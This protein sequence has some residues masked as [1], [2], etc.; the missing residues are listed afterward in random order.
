MFA[1]ITRG[2]SIADGCL[3]TPDCRCA[4][5]RAS[6]SPVRTSNSSSV[7]SCRLREHRCMHTCLSMETSPARAA[8]TSAVSCA[9]QRGVATSRSCGWCAATCP[10]TAGH[11]S[12][13]GACVSGGD[14]CRPR[15]PPR[16]T[17]VVEAVA[18]CDAVGVR[19]WKQ[20]T[21]VASMSACSVSASMEAHPAVSDGS[22]KLWREC[23]LA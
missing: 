4:L 16:R 18:G 9:A 22:S 12:Y 14:K 21:C 15:H 10:T 17:Q 6:S 3:D 13:I 1:C 7:H 19:S 2:L 20:G 23:E 5:A 11:V 8:P